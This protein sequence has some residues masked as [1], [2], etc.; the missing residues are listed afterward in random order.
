MRVFFL[1]LFAFSFTLNYA[2][3]LKLYGLRNSNQQNPQQG[4]FEFVQV[5][6]FTAV[7]TSLFTIT[8]SFAVGAGASTY[9]HDG[10]R[11]IFWGRNDNG[12]DFYYQAMVDSSDWSQAPIAGS[13]PIALQYD[14]QSQ[15]T[16]GLAFDQGKVYLVKLDLAGGNAYDSLSI[17]G[18]SSVALFSDGY[19]SNHHRY[20]FVGYDQ[21]NQ[22]RLYYLNSQN[23]QIITQPTLATDE[24]FRALQFDHTSNQLIGLLAKR[25]S[26]FPPDPITSVDYTETFLVSVDTLTG[27]ST[28]LDSVPILAGYQTGI[29]GGSIDFDQLSRTMVMV[30]RED[31]GNF[32]LFLIDVANA[33]VISDVTFPEI[34]YE[35]AVD[36]QVFARRAYTGQTTQVEAKPEA[37]LKLSPNP[38][39]SELKI[40]FPT[41]FQ[42]GQLR[43]L[44]SMGQHILLQKIGV[45]QGFSEL[46]V[47]HLP[48]GTYHCVVWNKQGDSWSETFVKQ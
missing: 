47:S 46:Q 39:S 27:Q 31:T 23:G 36:N 21:S 30:A 1:L 41:S 7:G 26:N 8:N 5:D 24:Y 15:Q 9:D 6:P 32:R 43:L 40:E 10:R 29:A 42:G 3:G 38:A 12:Q 45:N 2:Q 11:Y 25:N 22:K 48:A 20:F 19:N 34:V 35:L 37:R 16:Y 33:Q 13:P 4:D 17:A 14:L 28:L 44:N 18:L